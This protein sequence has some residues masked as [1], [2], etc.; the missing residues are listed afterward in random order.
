MQPLFGGASTKDSY[1]VKAS[2]L[3]LD[4]TPA[5]AENWLEKKIEDIKPEDRFF[6]QYFSTKRNAMKQGKAGGND[7][8]SENEMD[9]ED[10][11]SALVKSRPDVEGDDDDDV[12]FGEEDF[13]SMDS[14]S[15][16]DSDNGDSSATDSENESEGSMVS[17]NSHEDEDFGE[18]VEAGFA[19]FSE[20][21]S[22]SG[23][24]SEKSSRK[25]TVDEDPSETKSENEPGLSK[26][27]RRSNRQKLKD[28]PLFASADEYAEY[29][30]SDDE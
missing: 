20:S 14:E 6:Y 1:L 8:E 19:G 13:M 12:D 18:G 22:E 24:E 4:Q 10:I 9:E 2:D 28:L 7:D 5:N 11:W 17:A 21:D 16:L 23:Q 30:K 25:R 15:D 3:I 26:K 29:M 27:K